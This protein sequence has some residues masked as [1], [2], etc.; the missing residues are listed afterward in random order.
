MT[1]RKGDMIIF[2]ITRASTYINIQM[3]IYDTF[4]EKK[5]RKRE[6]HSL[7]EKCLRHGGGAQSAERRVVDA[8]RMGVL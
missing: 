5:K 7:Y 1:R 6:W 4:L 8:R 2:I 3:T